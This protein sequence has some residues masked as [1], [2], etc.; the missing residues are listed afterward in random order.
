M[1]SHPLLTA[2]GRK[3]T[4]HDTWLTDKINRVCSH[5]QGRFHLN[6]KGD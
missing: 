6:E 1:T 4:A 3:A 2:G 5:F